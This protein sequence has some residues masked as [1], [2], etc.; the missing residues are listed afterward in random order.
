M[1]VLYE[2][3]GFQQEAFVRENTSLLIGKKRI[4]I[5]VEKYISF[6]IISLCHRAHFRVLQGIDLGP[7]L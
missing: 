4:A 5:F 3:C 1:G 2:N 6:E 7:I